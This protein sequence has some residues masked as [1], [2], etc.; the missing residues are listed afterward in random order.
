M[1]NERL[2]IAQKTS[3][4]APIATA[5]EEGEQCWVVPDRQM[6]IKAG[7]VVVAIG[8]SSLPKVAGYRCLTSQN[9]NASTAGMT[10]A[11]DNPTDRRE[12]TGISIDALSREVTVTGTPD[13]IEIGCNVKVSINNNSNVQRP[14]QVVRIVRSDGRVMASSAT[15][16]IRDAGDHEESSYNLT[17]VDYSPINNGSYRITATRETGNAGVVSINVNESQLNLRVYN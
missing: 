12:D 14:N 1:A 10:I 9:V 15:G 7:G 6:Y 2:I 8:S 17:A 4:G 16:Y 5:L 3:A 11:W 13:H